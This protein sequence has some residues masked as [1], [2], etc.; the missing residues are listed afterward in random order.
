MS[1]RDHLTKP[2]WDSTPTY[3]YGMLAACLL[4]LA[5]HIKWQITLRDGYPYERYSTGVALIM[6]LLNHLAYCFPWR[7]SVTVALRMLAWGW[8]VCGGAYILYWYI[9]GP[10]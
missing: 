4:L 2:P 5:F 6:L 3:R 10:V 7:T 1:I 9:R 8:L